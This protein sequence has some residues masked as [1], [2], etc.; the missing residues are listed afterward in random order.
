MPRLAP[1]TSATRRTSGTYINP[2]KR[3]VRYKAVVSLF[4]VLPRSNGESQVRG[5]RR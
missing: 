4:F 5:K 3:F 2:T 1:V